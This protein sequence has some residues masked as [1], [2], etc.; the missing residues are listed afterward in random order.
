MATPKAKLLQR[1]QQQPSNGSLVSVDSEFFVLCNPRGMKGACDA[2]SCKPL[3]GHRFQKLTP[4][5][6]VFCCF[7]CWEA[8]F[9]GKPSWIF[10]GQ[11]LPA[12]PGKPAFSSRFYCSRKVTSPE[13]AP[14][15]FYFAFLG[16][17]C[18]P[19]TRQKTTNKH[20]NA[21]VRIPAWV[22]WCILLGC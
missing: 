2:L 21:G 4:G 3:H 5:V 14:F 12:K 22:L 1:G 16:S 11:N 9:S 17:P 20:K 18:F 19:L 13:L 10:L 6:P 7:F 15:F 8:H